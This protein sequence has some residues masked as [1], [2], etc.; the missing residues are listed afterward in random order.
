MASYTG[1]MARVTFEGSNL[2]IP[3][4]TAR[5]DTKNTSTQEWEWCGAHTRLP[6]GPKRLKGW[7]S[8]R[9]EGVPSAVGL[10]DG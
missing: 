2:L 5:R 1:G 3:R 9:R 8:G 7:L 4:P 6:H 10:C